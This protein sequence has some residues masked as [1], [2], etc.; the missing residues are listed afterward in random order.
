MMEC[1]L[2]AAWGRAETEQGAKVCKGNEE[3]LRG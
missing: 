3:T 2:V 1:R